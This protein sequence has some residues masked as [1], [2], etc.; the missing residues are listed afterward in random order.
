MRVGPSS[1]EEG[2]GM[3]WDSVLAES[4]N[5]RASVEAG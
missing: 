1:V 4:G 5:A 3:H 2:L